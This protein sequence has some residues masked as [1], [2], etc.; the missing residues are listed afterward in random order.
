[1]RYRV[2]L[3]DVVQPPSADVTLEAVADDAVSL[4]ARSAAGP[5]YRIG[6]LTCRGTLRLVRDLPKSI[7]LSLDSEG[8]IEIE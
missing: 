3:Q 7:G 5:W 2:A 1:M 4:N 6:I 8:R